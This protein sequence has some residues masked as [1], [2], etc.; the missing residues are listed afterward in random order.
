M[1]T[2]AREVDTCVRN[3]AAEVPVKPME[4]VAIC[5]QETWRLLSQRAI[6]NLLTTDVSDDSADTGGRFLACT[7]YLS[8]HPHWP[9]Q[10]RKISHHDTKI[11]HGIKWP[12]HL[13]AQLWRVKIIKTAHIAEQKKQ[14][15]RTHVASVREG[16]DMSL[17]LTCGQPSHE[18]SSAVNSLQEEL[19]PNCGLEINPPRKS[20]PHSFGNHLP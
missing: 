11:K 12:T 5:Q 3:V 4:G 10:N 16:S 9:T 2:P 20:N 17:W 18:C 14:T 6:L 19:G 8:H 7:K 1:H 13:V 15:P